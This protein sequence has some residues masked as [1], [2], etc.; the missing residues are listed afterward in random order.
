MRLAPPVFLVLLA[1]LLA[2]IASSAHPGRTAADGCHYCRTNC[3]S[4]GVEWDARHCDGGAPTPQPAPDPEPTPVAIVS[5]ESA[6][7]VS[8]VD[9]DTIK[10]NRGSGT[11]S[12]R[13][14]GIDTPETVH[15]TKPVECF[16]KEASAYLSSL[17]SPGAVVT[18]KTDSIGDTV[19]KYGR[20]LRYV[21]LEAVDINAKLVKQGYAYA[22]TTYPF[23]R[24]SDYVAYQSDAEKQGLGLWAPGVCD[25]TATT[26]SAA[27][28]PIDDFSLSNDE[29][30]FEEDRSIGA[31]EKDSSFVGTVPILFAIAGAV[32]GVV[33]RVRKKK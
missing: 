26:G 11:E 28:Q 12:V 15:P 27:E 33:Y 31:Y 19:D 24:S 16:G 3:D 6:T 1:L 13:L 5:T 20:L 29:L 8:V 9:G 7:V 10:V 32:V 14:I 18:L 21:E 25:V 23:S 30:T 4:W 17:L 2:P 22:Y